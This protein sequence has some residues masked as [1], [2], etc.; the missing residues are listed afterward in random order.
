MPHED[1]EYQRA[2][3]ESMKHS[4]QTNIAPSS[5][6]SH[7]FEGAMFGSNPADAQLQNV[8]IEDTEEEILR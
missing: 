5:G 6:T 2:I 1:D 8:H 4:A 7:H 3:Q